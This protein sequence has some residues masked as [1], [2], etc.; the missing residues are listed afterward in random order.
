[1]LHFP[2]YKSPFMLA[3]KINLLVVTVQGFHRIISFSKANNNL[4]T[5]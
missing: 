2:N 1:M 4:V 5:Y 3:K